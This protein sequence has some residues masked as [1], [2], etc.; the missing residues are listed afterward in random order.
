MNLKMLLF[1]SVSLVIFAS[2]HDSDTPYM[3]LATKTLVV[4]A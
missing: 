3:T 4:E 1:A 2:C